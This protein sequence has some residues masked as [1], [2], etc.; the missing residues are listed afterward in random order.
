MDRKSAICLVAGSLSVALAPAS[1]DAGCSSRPG[2]PDNVSIQATSTT[3]VRFKWR[4]TTRRDEVERFYDIQLW[5]EVPPKTSSEGPTKITIHN[6]SG[7]RGQGPYFLTTGGMDHYD[8]T[9]LKPG[10]RYCAWIMARTER[11]KEGCTSE[12]WS[13]P[14]CTTTEAELKPVK[15]LGKL[16]SATITVRWLKGDVFL[17][18]GINFT[19]NAPVTI[20]VSGGPTTL[21]S[22]TVDSHNT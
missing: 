7:V 12:I 2:T 4:I 16:R 14:P 15:A 11:G 9:G 5:E 20:D 6:L 19:P 17:I 1:A 8:F 22:I 13:Y 10:T 18:K 21:K 3:S